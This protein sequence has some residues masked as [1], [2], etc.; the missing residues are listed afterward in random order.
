MA[1]ADQSSFL[2]GVVSREFWATP[3]AGGRETRLAKG[4]NTLLD[5]EGSLRRR[6]GTFQVP[7]WSHEGIA[8]LVPFRQSNTNQ[9]M[10]VFTDLNMD[11]FKG[12]RIIKSGIKTPWPEADLL[13][14]PE[15][16][17]QAGT[18]VLPV[19]RL[20]CGH[21][22]EP[23]APGDILHLRCGMEVLP[24]QRDEESI[25]GQGT[26]GEC[27]GRDPELPRLLLQAHGHRNQRGR[28]GSSRKSR[29]TRSTSR[30]WR[31]TTEY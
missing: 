18:Q 8:R 15:D 11:V 27:D 14:D 7:G 10:L 23:S 28:T 3:P 25:H 21:P 31:S 26:D 19:H 30:T 9:F 2:G 29:R 24:C 4:I 6:P 16:D 17:S 12:G 5:T 1:T 20:P 22:S 13:F